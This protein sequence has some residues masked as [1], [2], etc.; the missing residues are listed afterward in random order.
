V[1]QEYDGSTEGKMVMKFDFRQLTSHFQLY[2]NFVV[3]VPYGTGHINDT[4][5][6]T[7]DQGG[8]LLHYIIQRVNTNVFKAPEELM[9]N[10]LRVTRHIGAKI[11]D[12]RAANPATRRRT[13]EV[14]NSIYGKPYWRDPAGNFFRCYVFVENARSYDILET[15][16]QAYQ[17]AAAF[18]NFQADLA[19]LPQR[20]NE[21]IPDFHNTPSRLANLEKA[22]KEDKMGRLKSVSREFDFIMARGKECGVLIDLQKEG[23]LVE[24]VTHNDTKLNNVLID[25]LTGSGCCVI[26]L[27]TVMP[28]LPHYDFGDMVRTGT[29]PAAEDETDLGKVTMRFPMYEALLRGYLSGAGGFLNAT[30]KSLL[31]FSGKLITLEI[32]IRF[33]TDYLEGDVYFKIRRPDHNLDRCRTQLKLVASIEEQYDAMR[34]LADELA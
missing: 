11:R 29:S 28:G 19:D 1:E 5:Q 34:K 12:E 7:F 21:T 26:D 9:D 13:L 2:G 27:D 6:V 24:R 4:F 8:T 14:V 30:E 18:G 20:L 10:F 16:A 22:A 15:K 33:L 25:D 3:A 23:E 32:G 17:A 31:P